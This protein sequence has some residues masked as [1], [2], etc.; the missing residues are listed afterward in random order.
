MIF[1]NPMSSLNPVYTIGHQLIEAF[2]SH[3]KTSSEEAKIHVINSLILVGIDNPKKRM[4]Q[5][6]NEFS[7]GMLQRIIIAMA[8]LSHPQL[9]IADE[10]TTAL[11]VTIQA[12]IIELLI[13]LK[14]Q[15][16]MSIIFITHDLAVAAQICDKISIMY[17]GKIV[18][19]G[20]INQIFY[21]AVHP[22]TIGLLRSM[23]SLDSNNKTLISIDGSPLDWPDLT[24]GG[25]PF[26]I[27]CKYCMKICLKADPPKINLDDTHEVYCWNVFNNLNIKENEYAK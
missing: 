13:T 6:P 24:T 20:S 18:E 19:T 2:K 8:L 22:Y 14:K 4:K 16:A 12:Q 7:G 5:Y 25:C 17:S 11:D 9:L 26:A 1:Q 27:R 10:P 23:P 15:N 21:N 3:K